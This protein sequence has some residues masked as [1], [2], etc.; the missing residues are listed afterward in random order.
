MLNIQMDVVTVRSFDSSPFFTLFFKGLGKAVPRAEL[1]GAENRFGFWFAEVIILKVTVTIL[2]EEKASFG[3]CRFGDENT[4][5]G[6][7]G[8]VILYKL[9]I[10]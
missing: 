3:P 5:K 9:H 4:R 1:H 2:V 10:F 6:Q 8:G 7:P